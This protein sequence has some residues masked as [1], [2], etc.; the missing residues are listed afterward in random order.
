MVWQIACDEEYRPRHTPKAC[1]LLVIKERGM[2]VKRW[3]AYY[4]SFEEKLL[5]ISLA[6][7]VIL[8]LSQI[9]M[10]AA[11]NA[12][13]VWS[14]EVARYIFIWQIWLGTS[15]SYRRK[16]HISVDIIYD[17]FK[18]R[19]SHK[20]IRTV[21]DLIWLAFN[22]YLFY[23]GAKLVDSMITRHVLSAGLR[24]PLVYVYAALP[25]SAAILSLRLIGGIIGHWRSDEPDTP[26]GGDRL[27]EWS[28]SAEEVIMDTA[29]A[30]NIVRAVGNETARREGE[31][32]THG[33]H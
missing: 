24:L 11:F 28:H 23:A 2:P 8:I 22:L 16:S 29:H 19:L 14:E 3:I 18:S 25:V 17:I 30:E 7:N 32:K 13:L 6:V 5:I 12:S 21:I 31:V 20:I 33:C 10:R 1:P 9:I 27:Q 15:V 4:D 26:F